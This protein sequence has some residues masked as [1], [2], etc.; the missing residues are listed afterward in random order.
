MSLL[1]LTL[2][3]LFFALLLSPA[4]SL[5]Q[6]DARDEMPPSRS[7]DD[8]TRFSVG[9]GLG[10]VDDPGAVSLAFDAP[11]ELNRNVS[12][13]PWVAVALAENLV[14]VN[15]TANAR[16]T[17]DLFDGPKTRRLR[18][19]VQGGLGLNYTDDDQLLID[20]V[21]FLINTGL[22]LEYQVDEHV[23]VGT[24]AM[25]N[26]IPT[27]PRSRNFNVNVQLLGVRYRF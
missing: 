4:A 14:M 8:D 17:F 15:A 20:E 24:T 13:G 5:A 2:A 21:N 1:R 11:V 10:F 16:Y 18:P 22:G 19:F 12:V 7:P 26:V 27:A 3:T 6:E 23:T 9:F 25:F